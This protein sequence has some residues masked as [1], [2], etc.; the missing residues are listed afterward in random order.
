MQCL[1]CCSLI[2]KNL[3]IGGERALHCKDIPQLGI[4]FI[5]IAAVEVKIEFLPGIT[6]LRVPLEDIDTQPLTSHLKLCRT[7]ID[8]GLNHGSVL[9]ACHEGKSRS[10]TI[11][12]DYLLKRKFIVSVDQTLEFMKKQHPPTNPCR[13][14]LQYLKENYKDVCE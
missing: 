3:Y 6:Y 10:A 2:K 9:V 13:G 7:F 12:M 14:F 4:K 5:L 8:N 1:R 11:I